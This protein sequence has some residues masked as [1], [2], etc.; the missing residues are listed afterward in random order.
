[1]QRLKPVRWRGAKIAKAHGCLK[2]GERFSGRVGE[3]MK[4]FHALTR[5]EAFRFSGLYIR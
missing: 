1:M 4:L 5:E 2:L 3:G